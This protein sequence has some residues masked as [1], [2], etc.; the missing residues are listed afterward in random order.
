MV[1]ATQPLQPCCHFT[2]PSCGYSRLIRASTR[3]QSGLGS[4]PKLGPC[5]LR[6]QPSVRQ[7]PHAGIELPRVGQRLPF[8]QDRVA[9]H[10][11][12]AAR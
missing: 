7:H 10:C 5:A 1:I 12:T 9:A 11:R 3:R 6:V 2:A 4:A 8:G